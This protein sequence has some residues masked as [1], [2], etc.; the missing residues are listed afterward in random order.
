MNGQKAK[1]FVEWTQ[2][3]LLELDGIAAGTFASY[4]K[5]L[6]RPTWPVPTLHVHISI[7]F[8]EVTA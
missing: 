5:H 3:S 2:F 4:P 8:A 6:K 1:Q 7:P